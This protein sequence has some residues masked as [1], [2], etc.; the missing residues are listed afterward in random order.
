MSGMANK[1]QVGGSH[2]KMGDAEEHWDRVARLGLDYFQGQITKY[3]ERCW[4]KNGLQDLEK[5]QHFLTKYIE[6]KKA[7]QQFNPEP[8][9]IPAFLP[10]TR[11]QIDLRDQ[12][13]E[14]GWVGFVFEGGQSE[15]DLYTCRKCKQEVR[16]GLGKNPN[17]YHECHILGKLETHT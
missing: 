3:V 5:A 1:T 15:G 4:K 17:D 8:E 13:K 12:V 7:E 11:V 10:D 9:T 14:T 6:V 2:Y 16:T